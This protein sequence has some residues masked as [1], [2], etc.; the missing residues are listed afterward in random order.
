V[1]PAAAHTT[2][3][4]RSHR[5]SY[6]HYHS[7]LTARSFSRIY[8]QCISTWNNRLLFWDQIHHWT[9]PTR[10]ISTTAKSHWY[11]QCTS[12]EV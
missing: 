10:R 5:R 7:F 3:R 11:T 8:Q 4:R 2:P 1:A 12:I 9:G 6:R